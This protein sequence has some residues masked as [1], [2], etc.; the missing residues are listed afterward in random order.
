MPNIKTM[1][2]R[3][4]F[5]L[6]RNLFKPFSHRKALK[7]NLCWRGKKVSQISK[8]CFWTLPSCLFIVLGLGCQTAADRCPSRESSLEVGRVPLAR[9]QL[10]PGLVPLGWTF[11]TVLIGSHH[12]HLRPAGYWDRVGR[13]KLFIWKKTDQIASPQKVPGGVP[14]WAG[15]QNQSRTLPLLHRNPHGP[16]TDESLGWYG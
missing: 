1:G 2:R 14:L 4:F 5:T 10:L 15:N 16:G 12:S 3:E 9:P 7:L 6:R 13:R 8:F 11:L